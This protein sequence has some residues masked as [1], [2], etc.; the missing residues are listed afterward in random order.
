MPEAVSVKHIDGRTFGQWSEIDLSIGI[1]S[2]RCASLT[3]PFDPDRKDMRAAFEPLSFPPVT[4]EIGDE[5]FLTGKVNDVAPSVDAQ[6]STVGV[7]AY[8]TAYWLTVICAPAELPPFEF[9]N[10]DLKQIAFVV[11]GHSIGLVVNL[12]GAPGAKFHR[13]KCERDAELHGFLADLAL[14]RGFVVSD[15]A[16]GDLLFR[17]EGP[18]GSPVARLKG[19]PIG[20]VSA[21][22]QPDKWFSHITGRACKRAGT[23]NGSKYTQI[24]KLYRSSFPR[25]HCASVGDTGSADVPRATKATVGRMV[26]SVATYTVEDLPTWRD[27][28]GNL[29]QPN[30]TIM[31]TAPGAMIYKETELLIRSVRFKQRGDEETATL[32]LVLP[33]SFGGTQPK[34]LP[35]DS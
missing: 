15:T 23:Q 32:E 16:S 21:Q 18:T 33:G 11:A 6:Q 28:S 13:V 25:H 22:F 34:A 26:A 17:S 1:D 7:T 27:P 14:Q 5:L 29:W 24:N 20:K 10:L 12:D 31:I 2:Y 30:T 8:S 19:Q 35:W 4:V 3:G 9:N